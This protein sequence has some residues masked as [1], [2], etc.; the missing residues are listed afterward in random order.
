MSKK[1]VA[2]VTIL[3]NG[4]EDSIQSYILEMDVLYSVVDLNKFLTSIDGC[5]SNILTM[6]LEHDMESHFCDCEKE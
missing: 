6:T 5:K 4:F 1:V 3:K 2:K